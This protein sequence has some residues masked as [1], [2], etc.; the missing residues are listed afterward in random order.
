MTHFSILTAAGP[1]RNNHLCCFYTKL[2]LYVSSFYK[3]LSMTSMFCL[4]GS[5]TNSQALAITDVL[6]PETL[7]LCH[8]QFSNTLLDI[9]ASKVF[10]VHS[11]FS[12]EKG[13]FHQLNLVPP[14]AFLFVTFL[15]DCVYTCQFHLF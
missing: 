9:P 8:V 10:H 15:L 2:P 1:A 7:L 3:C 11:D 13:G 14:F 6:L 5:C 4:S 12:M